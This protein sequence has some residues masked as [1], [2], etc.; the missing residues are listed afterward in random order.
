M[1]V[2]R[3]REFRVTFALFRLRDAYCP[4]FRFVF[5]FVLFLSFISF[6]LSA[7]LFLFLFRDRV[8]AHYM[9]ENA[10]YKARTACALPVTHRIRDVC[11]RAETTWQIR[12]GAFYKR[13][14]V[15]AAF[16]TPANIIFVSRAEKITAFFP[17]VTEI[18][19]FF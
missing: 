4:S 18:N 12:R 7:C 14:T 15:R 1:V 17:L 2:C 19:S 8:R 13:T 5:V 6:R 16:S 9:C 10:R 3:R 11:A